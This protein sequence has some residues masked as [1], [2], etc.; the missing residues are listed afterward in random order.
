MLDILYGSTIQIKVDEFP[1]ED[2]PYELLVEGK[3]LLFMYL[4]DSMHPDGSTSK[5]FVQTIPTR[6]KYPEIPN[7]RLQFKIN[8]DTE[9]FK[10]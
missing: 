2:A 7:Y 6:E 5:S 9:L 1:P 10:W 8:Q 3:P 4:F